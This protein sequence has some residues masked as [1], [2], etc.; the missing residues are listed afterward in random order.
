MNNISLENKA[1]GK[2]GIVINRMFVGGYL[3]NNLGHEIINLFQ[4]DNGCHYLYLNSSGS[5]SKEHSEIGHMLMVKSGPKDCF[6]I[7]GLATGLTPVDGVDEPR[8][9]DIKEFVESINQEQL[10]FIASQPGGDIKYGGISILDLFNDAE[11]QNVFITF[12]ADKVFVPQNN[13]KLFLRYDKNKGNEAKGNER[14]FAIRQHNQPKTSLKSYL[15]DRSED[16]FNLIENL[17]RDNSI[18]TSK[19]IRKVGD[20]IETSQKPVSL[21]DICQIQDDENRISNALAYFLNRKDYKN[22]WQVFFKK[23]NISLTQ[24][25]SVER[26]V[27]AKIEDP[28]VNSCITPSGGRIDLLI[29]D[30]DNIIAIENKIKSDINTI[31]SDKDLESQLDRYYNYVSWLAETKFRVHNRPLTHFLILAPDYNIPS[32]AETVRDKYRIITYKN[33]YYFLKEPGVKEI[34][35]QDPNFLAFRDVIFRHT[36]SNQNEYLYYEMLE[37]FNNRI[38]E[39]RSV[40][41]QKNYRSTEQQNDK[42]LDSINENIKTININ[43]LPMAEK[44][45]VKAKAQNR[46]ALG[47]TNAYAVMFPNA[48]IE[49]LRA[50]FPNNIAP[51]KGV[52]EMF[53]SEEESQARD[54]AGNMKLY[55]SKPEE[56]ISLGDGNRVALCT[57]WTGKS[58]DRLKENAEKLGIVTEKVDKSEGKAGFELEFLNGWTPPTQKKKGKGITVTPTTTVA[59]L[60]KEFN[61]DFDAALKVYNGRNLADDNERL[62]NLGARPGVLECRASRTVGSFIEE[63]QARFGLTVTIWTANEWVKVIDGVTLAKIKQLPKQATKADM[64]GLVSYKR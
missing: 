61:K 26:E 46:T 8:K 20:H 7:I 44:I 3:T 55:F 38:N 27:S 1:F 51:D 2:Q 63:A 14:Y 5:F 60:K 13:L 49:D 29:K 57:M 37:K 58:L 35:E 33:L 52:D 9:K 34:V 43:N 25:F 62:V 50:Q 18:W 42:Y 28:K 30:L 15:D 53:I 54:D 64:E 47:I 24:G 31:S 56:M 17:I 32:L 36:F 59:D 16:Q 41:P 21:F 23:F 10:D 12:K 45:K 19:E 11:Q 40:I 39:F 6:E 4:A 22:L 48:T